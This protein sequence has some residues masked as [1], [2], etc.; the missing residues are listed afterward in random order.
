MTSLLWMFLS[1]TSPIPEEVY[2]LCH[3]QYL[4]LLVLF[5]APILVLPKL[6]LREL[7]NHDWGNEGSEAM[8]AQ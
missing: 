1:P 8:K 2:Y 3:H 6:W 4:I 7:K 5:I